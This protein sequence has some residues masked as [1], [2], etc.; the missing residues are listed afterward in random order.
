MGIKD[1]AQGILAVKLQYNDIV[2]R[3]MGTTPVVNI[4]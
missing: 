4:A 2:W 1:T 3:Q